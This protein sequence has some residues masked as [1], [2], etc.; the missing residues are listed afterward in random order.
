M[1]KS[2]WAIG[3][4]V[5]AMTAGAGW[6]Q[7]SVTATAVDVFQKHQ[8]SVVYVLAVAKVR[9]S[10][11]GRTFPEQE[12]KVEAIGTVVGDAGMTVVSYASLDPAMAY[13]GRNMGGVQLDVRTNFSEVK[14]RLSDGTEV[15]ARVVLTDEDLD[16]AFVVPDPNSD[17]AQG[18]EF[19][20]VPLEPTADP[21]I[22]DDVIALG[23]LDKSLDR[24]PTVVLG[25]VAALIKKP[26]VFYVPTVGTFG[27]PVFAAD[28]KIIGLAVHRIADGSPGTRV[29]LPAQDIRELIPQALEAAR[30]APAP[31]P[32]TEP[33]AGPAESAE[34][35][36][37]AE[38]A[39]GA[40]EGETPQPPP[41]EGQGEATE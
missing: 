39:E 34:P 32:T 33:A 1:R 26:R 2:I 29:V 28:G 36:E 30:K 4:L 24:R 27:A 40:V 25:H 9:V 12:A 15:P 3:V 13:R 18:A 10:G 14:V 21:G 5:L 8:D 19:V 38:G 35:T 20:P 41:T 22:L 6:A 11:G 16:L 37:P 17:E 31:E 23:R 7:Q